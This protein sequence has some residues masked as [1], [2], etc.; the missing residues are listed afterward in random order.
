V[1][2]GPDPAPLN[3]L[4]QLWYRNTWSWAH[5]QTRHAIHAD[6]P[7]AARTSHPVLGERWWYVAAGLSASAKAT[8]DKQACPDLLFTEN[9]TKVERLFGVPNG[10]PFVKD[11]INDAVVH[12]RAD[13]VNAFA[14]AAVV[15]RRSHEKV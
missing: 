6:G 3:L 13:R 4:P 8:A 15:V 5:G 12:G 7:G 11:G 9:D 10:S 1:N 2:H 14:Y